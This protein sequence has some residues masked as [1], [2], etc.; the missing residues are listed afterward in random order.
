MKFENTAQGFQDKI[1][2]IAAVAGKTADQVYELW[3]KY[4]LQCSQYGQSPILFEFINWYAAAMGGNPAALSKALQDA[5]EMVA[6]MEDAE[7][8]ADA[9]G[10]AQM[11]WQKTADAAAACLAPPDFSPTSTGTW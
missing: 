11:L 7:A 3:R 10:M 6:A 2:A 4:D 9:R 8:Q 1:Y 5:E